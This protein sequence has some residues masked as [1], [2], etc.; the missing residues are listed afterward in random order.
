MKS[1]N[2]NMGFTTAEVASLGTLGKELH[3][4]SFLIHLLF[5]CSSLRFALTLCEEPDSTHG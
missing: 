4:S 1:S 5:F 3:M 2:L